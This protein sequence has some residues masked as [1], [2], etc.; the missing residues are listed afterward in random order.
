MN[1][2]NCGTPLNGSN[3][4][5][6]CG[7]LNIGFEIDPNKTPNAIEQ[8]P[9]QNQTPAQ[10]VNNQPNMSDDLGI[11]ELNDDNPTVTEGMAPPSL[12][13]NQENIEANEAGVDISNAG[14][15]SIYSPEEIQHQ[16]DMQK[17]AEERKK[18]DVNIEIPQ[19]NGPIENIEMPTD[20]SAPS[21]DG[22]VPTVG[23]IETPKEEEK[24]T[25][26]KLGKKSIKVNLG[27]KTIPF[28]LAIIVGVVVLIFGILIGSTVFGKKVYTPGGNTV[29]PTT[30]IDKVADGKN[31]TT[32][33]GNF[34]FK[35]PTSY[36]YDKRENGIIIY[37]SD[38]TF[39][40]YIRG[41]DASYEDFASAKTSLKKTIENMNI[42]V[43]DIKELAYNEHNYV[44]V[45]TTSN[46]TNY[47]IAFTGRTIDEKDYVFYIEIVTADNTGAN[48]YLSIAD[49]VIYNAEFVENESNMEKVTIIDILDLSKTTVDAY[50]AT[51]N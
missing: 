7:A 20:G 40:V 18:Q 37:D 44:V 6:N 19:N 29:T 3:T 9:V 41:T 42:A 51:K 50:K 14:S 28:K 21:I 10:V 25:T 24:T 43:N 35:I 34:S 30:K 4:C 5:P 47:L 11:E 2:A 26:I 13:V 23:D 12:D 49:D 16:Q 1:C 22:N 27:K 33:A 45:D 38:D 17:Q 46:M 8:V 36:I 15:E 31:N 32:V 39:R 48:D